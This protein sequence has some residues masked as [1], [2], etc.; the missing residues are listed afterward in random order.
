ML[1][2]IQGNYELK[3]MSNNRKFIFWEDIIS[4]HQSSFLRNLAEKEN[5]TLVVEKEMYPERVKQGWVTPDV[6]KCNLIIS[7]TSNEVD[8]IFN[9]HSHSY[10]FFDGVGSVSFVRRIFKKAHQKKLKIGIISEPFN[11]MGWKGFLRLIRGRLE[12]LFHKDITFIMAIGNR[13]R[14][15]YEKCGYPKEKIYDWGYFI[16]PKSEFKI[17]NIKQNSSI[18]LIFVGLLNDRKGIKELLESLHTLKTKDWALTVIGSG[19]ELPKLQQLASQMPGKI[20]FLGNLSNQQVM[21]KIACSDLLILPSVFDG[22]G[23]VINEALTMGTPV[24]ASENCG[25]S[26]LLDG[27]KRGEKFDISQINLV[28]SKWLLKKK[29]STD[30]KSISTWAEN[31]ISG[32]AASEY[33]IK[34]IN[35]YE[36]GD[37]RS[38]APWLKD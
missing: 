31:N 21:Q 8:G 16:E 34:I 1:F 2:K 38:I 9:N 28:I 20:N 26:V 14:W 5:V 18:K 32:K 37:G 12:R 10:H 25:A 35:E 22:W 30:R 4:P 33:F 29:N 3:D 19:R 7:P 36:K 13:G 15:W 6:G 23:A 24:L 27:E 11:W 17:E